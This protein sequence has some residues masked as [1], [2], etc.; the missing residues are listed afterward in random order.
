MLQSS[1]LPNRAVV[2]APTSIAFLSSC[3]KRCFDAETE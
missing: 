2:I 1:L 3:G